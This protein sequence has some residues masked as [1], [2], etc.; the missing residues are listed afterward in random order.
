MTVNCLF[1]V[2]S[3]CGCKRLFRFPFN[4]KAKIDLICS[5]AN[6]VKFGVGGR[7]GKGGEAVDGGV[8]RSKGQGGHRR[9]CSST[10]PSPTL[11]PHCALES[12]TCTLQSFFQLLHGNSTHT[13]R[14]THIN[15][16]GAIP[17]RSWRK[18][19]NAHVQLHA[20]WGFNVGDG[21]VLLMHLTWVLAVGTQAPG[22]T[23]SSG[24]LG[25]CT[26]RAPRHVNASFTSMF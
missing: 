13:D 25:V 11:V 15:T 26:R 17:C 16:S 9:A 12:C 3:Q 4:S 8:G 1:F 6:W 14:Q 24:F 5:G 22:D 18:D 21:D 19:S 20:Q 2:L 10:T 7:W 23:S